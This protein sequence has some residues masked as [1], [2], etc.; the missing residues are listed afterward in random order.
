MRVCHLDW[1]VVLLALLVGLAGCPE[2]PD[3]IPGDDDT[4]EADDDDS[5]DDSLPAGIHSVDGI[6]PDLPYDDLE[7]LGDLIDDAAVVS[8]GETIHT[9]GGFYQAKGRLIRYLVEV[10]GFRAVAIESPWV[11][12]ELVADFVATGAGDPQD[13]VV[14]GLF[15]VWAGQAMLDLV[16]WLRAWNAD[17]PDDTVAFFGFDIQQPWAD[18]AGLRQFLSLALPAEAAELN[19]SVDRCNGADAASG[20]EYWSDPDALEIEEDDHLV[21]GEVL[22]ELQTRFDGEAAS[23]IAATSELELEMAWIHLIGLI[24][25]EEEAYLYTSDMEGSYAARDEGMAEVFLRLWDLWYPDSRV[26]L[27]AHNWHIAAHTELMVSSSVQALNMGGHLDDALG[28]D[29][30]PIGLLAYRVSIDWPGIYTGELDP[31]AGDDNVSRMLHDELACDYLLV[32][33]AFPGA[34]TPFLE[35]GGVYRIGTA[36]TGGDV[37][38]PAEHYR[39]LFFLEESPMM[40]ALAW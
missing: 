40:D 29:Y 17:H 4:S 21:C 34:A 31:P 30:A 32:D 13:A 35:P 33:L 24:A 25:W 2:E 12:A 11:D 37:L 38:V 23:L 10:E 19:A 5:A 15:G 16:L 18:G 28:D 36:Q 3:D 27:W 14:D 26:A 7:P 6:D 22:G 39:G 9:S 20:P 1:F 8:L